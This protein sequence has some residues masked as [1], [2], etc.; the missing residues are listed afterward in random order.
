M[1]LVPEDEELTPGTPEYIAAA[2]WYAKWGPFS[3]PNTLR[4]ADFL[5]FRELSIS[6]NAD[7][8]VEK[9]GWQDYVRGLTFGFTASNIWTLNHNSFRGKIHNEGLRFPFR[10]IP[11]SVSFSRSL[12]PPKTLLWYARIQI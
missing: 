2:D 4:R 5:K 10:I 8:L 7:K 12:P 11:D 3:D 6:Y 9:F 1:G